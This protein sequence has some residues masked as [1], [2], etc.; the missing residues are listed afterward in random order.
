MATIA[1]YL[2]QLQ[3]DKE[4]L[5][6]S[7]SDKGVEVAADATF[8]TLVP[9][10]DEVEEMHQAEITN[11]N[12]KLN[13]LTTP[14]VTETPTNNDFLTNLENDKQ[15]LVDNLNAKGVEASTDETFTSL[16]P[17][18]NEIEGGGGS[19]D[20]E[21]A[22]SFLSVID[23]TKGANCTKLP[24]GI[25]SIREDAFKNCINLA[26]TTLPDSVTTIG[27]N[28]FYSCDNLR[29]TKLPK[30]LTSIGNYGFYFCENLALTALPDTLTT[31][32]EHA[33]EGCAELALTS[34]PESATTI[35][36]SAFLKNK[37]LALT[38]LPSNLKVV[39]GGAFQGCERL[40]LTSLP[41]GLSVIGNLAFSGCT[42]IKL[43]SIPESVSL[44]GQQSFI[45]C[46][47]IQDLTLSSNVS[48]LP[49]YAFKSSGL[50]NLIIKR[51][52]SV[53][54]LTSNPLENTPLAAGKGCVFVPAEMVESYKANSSW[55]KYNIA[56]SELTSLDIKCP[57]RLNMFTDN[58]ANITVLYNG[59]LKNAAIPEQDGHTIT[60]EG[61]AVLE[62]D[63]LT[64]TEDTKDGD[65]ITITATSS[66]D[67]SIIATKEIAIYYKECRLIVNLNNG[68]WVD[69]GMV[70]DDGQTIYQ[71]DAGSYHTGNGQS[72]AS[73]DVFG[74]T[75]V[76]L[77]IKNNAENSYDY[78]ET[79]E[80]DTT[81]V[82]SKGKFSAKGKNNTYVTCTYELDGGQHSIPIMFSKDSSGDT[83]TDRG[84]FY[85]E[86]CE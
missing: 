69:S 30:N 82:R 12:D 18:I 40:A 5:I 13:T 35:G 8:T 55:S 56:S 81:P 27:K 78:V 39:E 80:V 11:I 1:E 45:E 51:T 66:Y 9:K 60:V 42:N 4:A 20:E 48:D 70:A 43:T 22:A 57:E 49:L 72:I 86:S 85:I 47:G 50:K 26:L 61:N 75:K 16:I 64:L 41:D 83:G 53:V 77:C 84:Y 71:S 37:K 10:V 23:N 15:A 25:T 38:H 14:E 34:L 31:I 21:L 52:K 33:F 73:V 79:F 76:T 68:Q 65:I 24:S 59:Y 29:L 63:V 19:G 28:A 58:T 46:T 6:S 2:L 54:S 67:N 44:I 32:G 62:G 36:V 3:A 17:K 74:Y 7:L